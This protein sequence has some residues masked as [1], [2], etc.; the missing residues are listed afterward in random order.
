MTTKQQADDENERKRSESR[1]T[2]NHQTWKNDR[3]GEN[4]SSGIVRLCYRVF[5]ISGRRTMT[6]SGNTSVCRVSLMPS[7][8]NVFA[9]RG[10]HVFHNQSMVMNVLL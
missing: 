7:A 10:T 8:D 3:K 6:H 5:N 4:M 1:T 2:K 9:H